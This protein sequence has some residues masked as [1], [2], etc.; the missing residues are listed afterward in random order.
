MI[1]IDKIPIHIMQEDPVTEEYKL[2][3]VT[4]TKG[5]MANSQKINEIIDTLK[6]LEARL[7]VQE[8]K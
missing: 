3:T 8:N 7:T 4:I 5:E 2:G 6:E 1:K